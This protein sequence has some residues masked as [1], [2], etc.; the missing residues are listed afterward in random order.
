MHANYIRPGGIS[1]D[2]PKGTLESIY[3]FLMQFASRID[4]IEDL[5]T[6]N[7]I[8]HSRLV[9]IGVVNIQKAF[10][11][12]FSGVLVRGSGALWDLRKTFPYENY[13]DFFFKIPQG[14]LGDCFDRYLIRIAEMRSSIKIIYDCISQI[15]AG[16]VKS[17]NIKLNPSKYLMKG[18]MEST[19]HHFKFMSSGLILP[20]SDNYSAIE[21]PKGEFGVY[22]SSKGE[23]YPERIKILAPG[24]FHLQ[25][26]K[27][28]GYQHLLADI[29]TIIGTMDIV[30]GEVDR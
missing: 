21:A 25:G 10:S 29:V 4:E 20:Q 12:G 8:W 18:T 14:N 16:E 28:M 22:I 1:Q 19:I 9:T 30:F 13:Q 17:V 24:Y 11:W 27:I 7:R 23:K 5:L 26:I 6:T 2:I 3:Q 15:E